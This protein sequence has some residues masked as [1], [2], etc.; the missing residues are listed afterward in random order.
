MK[1]APKGKQ[2]APESLL[3]DADYTRT[4][5]LEKNFKFFKRINDPRFGDISI[6]Q[7]PQSREFLAVREKKINDRAEAGRQVLAARQR[8]QLKSP[9]LLELKDYSVVKQSELCSSFYILKYFYEYPRSDLRK[10]IQ[11]RQRVR[12]RG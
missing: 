3:K 6:I 4:S 10:E 11:E 7:N 8:V 1:P 12:V 5:D 9:F 2:P